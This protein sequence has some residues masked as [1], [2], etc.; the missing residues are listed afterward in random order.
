LKHTKAVKALSILFI[1]VV[2][3]GAIYFLAPPFSLKKFSTSYQGYPDPSPRPEQEP[4]QIV[5]I[6]GVIRYFD[7][8]KDKRW[9]AIATSKGITIYDLKTLENIHS[10]PVNETITRVAFSP[11][12]SHLA[13]SGNIL[14]GYQSGP[15]FLTLWDT[16]SWQPVYQY[17][18][19]EDEY[20]YQSPLAW[21]PDGKQIAFYI[22]AH[23][24][25]I[26]DVASGK[27]SST[28]SDF[29]SMPFDIAWS[30][31]GKR[32]V[33]T[34][35]YGNGIRRWRLDTG[36]RVRL[37]NPDL[38]PASV[39]EWSPDGKKIATGHYGGSLCLWN[40]QNNTCEGNIKAHFNW[41]GSLGWSPNGADLAS[42]S[43]AIRV[44]DGSNGAMKSAFGF[45]DGVNYT[46]LQWVDTQT[47]VTLEELYT[48]RASSTIRFWDVSAQS[49]TLAFRGWDNAQGYSSSGAMLVL[50]D[51]QIGSDYSLIQVSL[52]FD[53]P[54]YSMAGAWNLAMTDE[55]G[56]IYPLIDVTPPEMDHN[57]TR[58]Y[59]TAPLQAGDY[60]TLDL[61]GFPVQSGLPMM[62]D[63]SADPGQF[64]FDPS[65]LKVGETRV[66][67]LDID[68]NIGLLHLREVQRPSLTD[69]VFVFNSENVYNGVGLFSP[70]SSM[71]AT[72][73]PAEGFISATL[74]FNEMPGQAIDI[75]ITKVY[76]Q[77][78]GSWVLDFHAAESMF[79][80]LPPARGIAPS[81]T[82]Q[83]E[84]VFTSQEPIFLRVQS[85]MDKYFKANVRAGWLHMKSEVVSENLQPGQVYPPPYYLEDG[86]FEVDAEGHVLKNLTTDLDE[87]GSVIQQNLVVG[88]QSLNLTTGEQVEIPAPPLPL[89]EI[90]FDLDYALTHH[91]SISLEEAA[92]DDGSDCLLITMTD[93]GFGRRAWINM[94]TGQHVKMQ[95]IELASDGSE[96]V[97]YTQTYLP[98]EWF[99]APPQDVQEVF[100]K[101][102]FP[103]P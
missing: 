95:A 16:S 41:V 96:V 1:V 89:M 58:I 93:K 82:S 75:D 11:D 99:P 28:L 94:E 46:E 19:E 53:S 81:P 60:I 25:S 69:L 92:C 76:F 59:Q 71:S 84:A 31:D 24:L 34:G 79:A 90:L 45:Y 47:I 10:F 5:N 30:P 48:E 73:L 50:D 23:G 6:P 13:A 36:K 74:S 26:I 100:E 39:V 66:S 2:V 42:A 86:W 56:E 43:G 20:S 4:Q 67:N 97:R 22:P 52:R 63:T 51:V 61:T 78:M 87:A 14:K 7:I 38:Q 21:S 12:T 70:L 29:A 33:A 3:L 54:D 40:T 18:S 44:W 88:G 65:T 35:D 85:L 91:L 9:I 17:E 83:P 37:W 57:I 102:V 15:M 101:V 49:E 27:T 55:Q 77:G 32:I 8:S 98:L 103:A 62:L 72:N 64:T 68:T 80:E